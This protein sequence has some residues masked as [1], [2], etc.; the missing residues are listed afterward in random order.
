MIVRIDA[1]KSKIK[2]QLLSSQDKRKKTG[3]TAIDW[4]F[5]KYRYRVANVFAKLKHFLSVATR[6]DKL[7][8][9]FERTVALTC[10]FLVLAM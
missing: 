7:H 1:P 10:T 5:Y 4:C 2:L 6:Y 8:R 9:N 3:N